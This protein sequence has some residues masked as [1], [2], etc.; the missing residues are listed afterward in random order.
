M[1]QLKVYIAGKVSKESVFGQHHWRDGFCEELSKKSGLK[2][3]NIDPTRGHE[4]FT[5]SQANGQFVLG[6]NS[7]MIRLS[8]VVIVN[9]TDDISVGGS[10]EILLAKYFKKPV[11][12]LAPKGGKFRPHA[13]ELFGTTYKDW[14][15]PI[16]FQTCDVVVG[17][18]DELANVLTKLD[19]LPVKGM[20]LVDDALEYYRQN[21][22][23]KDT[24]LKELDS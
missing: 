2:I 15:D 1:K 20:Q 5:N 7:H 21:F 4:N 11:I 22:L 9:L 23:D 14:E 3:I 12:G 19:E 10:Q 13:K 16:V 6:R 8:D 17:D 24:Y 18:V